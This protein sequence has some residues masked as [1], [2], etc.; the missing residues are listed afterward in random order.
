MSDLR[1]KV[2]ETA[3]GKVL[4]GDMAPLAS[5]LDQWLEENHG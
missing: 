1:V 3:T 4:E 2:M 5:Q